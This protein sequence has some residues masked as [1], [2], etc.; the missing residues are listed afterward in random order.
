[1]LSCFLFIF[2]GCD[3]NVNLSDRVLFHSPC[4]VFTR[5]E[6]G[7][8]VFHFLFPSDQNLGVFDCMQL[9]TCLILIL[10]LPFLNFI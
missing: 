3:S 8:T 2:I 5:T 10:S 7:L 1:M 4:A 6:T 9:D